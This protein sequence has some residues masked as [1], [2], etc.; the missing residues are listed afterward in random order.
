[1]KRKPLR[2]RLR[3][4]NQVLLAIV[5]CIVWQNRGFTHSKILTIAMAAY[6]FTCVTMAVI[7]VFR[8]R[9]LQ[10]PLVSAAK[11]VSLTSALLSMLS[12][13][14]AMIA[15]FDENI[16]PVFRRAMTGFSGG[17]VCLIVL[18]QAIRMIV[19]STGEIRNLQQGAIPHAQR[20]AE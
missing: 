2:H 4:L 9:K 3:V 14:T 20:S 12:L 8:F 11:S 17:A 13:E 5:T 6:S 16:D 19:K 15:A 10:D 7:N 1:M 18:A